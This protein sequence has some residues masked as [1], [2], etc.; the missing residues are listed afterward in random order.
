MSEFEDSIQKVIQIKDHKIAAAITTYNTANGLPPGYPVK[1][2]DGCLSFIFEC[3]PDIEEVINLFEGDELRINASWH[4]E[5]LMQIEGN[6]APEPFGYVEPV[7][8]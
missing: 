2:R 8:E 5:T 4:Y 7:Q 1:D 6:L 3:T